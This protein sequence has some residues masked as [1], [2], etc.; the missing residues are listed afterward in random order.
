ML[1][2]A[3]SSLLVIESVTYRIRRRPT[4]RDLDK[5]VRA[6]LVSLRR[7]LAQ[8]TDNAE[9]APDAL[10]GAPSSPGIEARHEPTGPAYSSAQALLDLLEEDGGQACALPLLLKTEAVDDMINPALAAA[11]YPQVSRVALPLLLRSALTTRRLL[12][13]PLRIYSRI[14]PTG[15]VASAT[16]HPSSNRGR[17]CGSRKAAFVLA[18][19]SSAARQARASRHHGGPSVLI[20]PTMDH[21]READDLDRYHGLR[22]I[23]SSTS[24]R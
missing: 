20:P 21:S 24:A 13:R 23:V 19:T 10:E 12:H 9:P 4:R 2:V 22:A 1:V 8:S 16:L 6:A 5:D 11:T 15:H 14:R 17:S 18:G 3:L 7:R